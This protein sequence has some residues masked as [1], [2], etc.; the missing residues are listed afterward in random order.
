MKNKNENHKKQYFSS[1]TVSISVHAVLVKVL[2]L[3]LFEKIP[4]AVYEYQIYNSNKYMYTCM[5]IHLSMWCL[6][7]HFDC[8]FQIWH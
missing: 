5:S 3:Y 4:F 2:D 8:K 7:A 1:W 6:L